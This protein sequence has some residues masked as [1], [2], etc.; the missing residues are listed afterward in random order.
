MP[1]IAVLIGV[2]DT[3]QDL[4]YRVVL[5]RA[6]DHQAFIALVQD[7]IFGNHLAQG[8]FVKEMSRELAEVVHRIIVDEGPIESELITAVRVIGEI[9]GVNTVGDDENLNVIEQS[10]EGGLLITLDLIVCLLQ[11][12]ATFLELNLNKRKTI[13]EDG[14]VVT[15][16]FTPLDSNLVGNLEF[17]LAP[18][19]LV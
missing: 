3:V 7:D 19:V 5:V 2:L 8:T 1:D 13:D 12:Y 15:A 17:V 10:P 18:V 14:D 6:E 9:A 4:L 11:F 16:S